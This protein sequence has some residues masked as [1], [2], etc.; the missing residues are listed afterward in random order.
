VVDALSRAA[1][2]TLVEW[3]PR[4]VGVEPEPDARG[5]CQVA[6][7]MTLP[8][9]NVRVGVSHS[10]GHQIGARLNV[11]HG[12]TSCITLPVVMRWL[13]A[14]AETRM[15]VVI[16]AMGGDVGSAA[17]G[18]AASVAADL[19]ADLV[20]RLGLPSRLRE[21][22][23]SHDDLEAIADAAFVEA[24]TSSSARRLTDRRQLVELL[25]NM[26]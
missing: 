17:P 3:L 10:L 19:V 8:W 13:G 24:S 26:I 11:P 5:R 6:A 7:W 14:V 15:R 9:S 21:F 12:V 16:G 20:S 22:G 4:S 23:A 25:E 1:L 2:E 18:Q